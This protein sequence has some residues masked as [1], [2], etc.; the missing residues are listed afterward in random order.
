MSSNIFIKFKDV[1][2]LAD[3]LEFCR[4]HD[5][6]YSPNTVG[7]ETFY[8]GSSQLSV[9]PYGTLSSDRDGRPKWETARPPEMITHLDASTYFAGDLE[10]LA[11]VAEAVITAFPCSVEYSPELGHLL[12]NCPI[13]YE[14]A[15]PNDIV[16]TDF[17]EAWEKSNDEYSAEVRAG[18]AII[19]PDE[20]NWKLEISGVKRGTFTDLDSAFAFASRAYWDFWL[21][22]RPDDMPRSVTRG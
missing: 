3:W 19:S 20:Q 18:R 9:R 10:S 1:V 2:P 6:E 22:P 17:P 5:I 15:E 8:K 14:I 16:S 4:Q 12:V 21:G 7:Q 13:S 11:E